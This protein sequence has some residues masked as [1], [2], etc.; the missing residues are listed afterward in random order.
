MSKNYE[1]RDACIVPKTKTAYRYLLPYSKCSL[2][3]RIL[4]IFLCFARNRFLEII[5][6]VIQKEDGNFDH[7]VFLSQYNGTWEWEKSNDSLFHKMLSRSAESQMHKQVCNENPAYYNMK[8]W[9]LRRWLSPL[10]LCG[11]RRSNSWMRGTSC[12][13]MLNKLAYILG[14]LCEYWGRE[15]LNS[16]RDDFCTDQMLK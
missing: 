5:A 16:P 13:G 11:S 12:C 8:D 7:T 3:L 15:N 2:S 9:P 1:T 6:R 4:Y 10:P 14:N